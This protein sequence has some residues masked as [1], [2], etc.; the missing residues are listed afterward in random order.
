MPLAP[1]LPYVRIVWANECDEGVDY[2]RCS[3]FSFSLLRQARLEKGV[4]LLT[5]RLLF[6]KLGEA[7]SVITQDPLFFDSA[8]GLG[9]TEAVVAD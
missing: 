3:S 5:L 2:R 6:R 7:S 9:A 1:L 4:L 8:I